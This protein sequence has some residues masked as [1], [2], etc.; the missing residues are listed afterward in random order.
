VR[1]F[2]RANAGSPNARIFLWDFVV[3][4]KLIRLSL[5]K[6]E[7]VAVDERSLVGNPEF[8]LNERP[9]IGH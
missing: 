1:L 2:L 6:A 5:R 9:E 7:Y 8:A 4:V 3:S